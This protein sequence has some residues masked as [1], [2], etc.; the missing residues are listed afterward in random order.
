MLPGGSSHSY[1]EGRRVREEGGNSCDT[2]GTPLNLMLISGSGCQRFVKMCGVDS[3][4]AVVPVNLT[5]KTATR[6]TGLDL[7]VPSEWISLD[8]QHVR[9]CGHV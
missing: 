2:S 7:N 6:R 4:P 8:A 1:W 3:L 9:D 5:S